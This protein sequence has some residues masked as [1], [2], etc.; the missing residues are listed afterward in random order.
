MACTIKWHLFYDRN[1]LPTISSTF[2]E[3]LPGAAAL[4]AC[5]CSS[6]RLDAGGIFNM[7]CMHCMH[8]YGFISGRSKRDIFSDIPRSVHMGHFENKETLSLVRIRRNAD[9]M[10]RKGLL[11]RP[12]WAVKSCTIRKTQHVVWHDMQQLLRFSRSD[13]KSYLPKIWI[14][15]ASR[16]ASDHGKRSVDRV[17]NV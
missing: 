2:S 10:E 5:S 9:G 1:H 15:C 6:H 7:T 3:M 16:S 11:G 17:R 14:S 13:T 12:G 8:A 4:Y